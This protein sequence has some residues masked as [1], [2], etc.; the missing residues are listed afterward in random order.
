MIPYFREGIGAL[1]GAAIVVAGMLLFYEG[2]PVGPLRNV[3]YLGELVQGRVEAE[4]EKAR[5]GYVR[6]ARLIAAEARLAETER[7]LVA[8]RKALDGFAELLAEAQAREAAQSEQDA[9]DDAEFQA[10]LKAANRSCSIT[11]DDIRWLRR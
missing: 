7:Q 6:E 3:P 1:A 5:E 4:R 8:G 11:D 10:A 2:L 9:Q